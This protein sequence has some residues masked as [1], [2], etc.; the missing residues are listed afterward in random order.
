[1]RGDW[2]EE[3]EPSSPER[4][5]LCSREQE[6]TVHHLIPRSR[7]RK[8]RTKKVFSKQEMRE[9]LIHVCEGCH[10]NLHRCLSEKEMAYEYNTLEKLQSHPGVEK[11]SKWIGKKPDGYVPR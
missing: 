4:C 3:E 11:F 9:R 5:Q 10:T 2:E 1:M 6:L 8:A 7:H